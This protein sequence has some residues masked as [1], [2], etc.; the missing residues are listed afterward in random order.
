MSAS[1]KAVRYVL[2]RS[3]MELPVSLRPPQPELPLRSPGQEEAITPDLVA[4][5]IVERS[6][7]KH[8]RLDLGAPSHWRA[9]VFD[10]TC[11]SCWAA[12]SGKPD[13]A[14]QTP[15]RD[16]L[17]SRTVVPMTDEEELVSSS[18]GIRSVNGTTEIWQRFS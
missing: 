7:K 10:Q 1:V 13:E 9:V 3:V 15:S 5:L 14:F 12:C 6:L 18:T 8:K 4:W 16:F 17:V 2:K 11:G